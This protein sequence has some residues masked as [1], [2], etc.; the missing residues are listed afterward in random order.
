LKFRKIDM[1]VKSDETLL[2]FMFEDNINVLSKF[3]K[4]NLSNKCNKKNIMRLIE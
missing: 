1:T 2:F 4:K 3:R